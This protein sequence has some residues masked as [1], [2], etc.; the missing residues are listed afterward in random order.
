MIR[1]VR[2]GFVGASRGFTFIEL[3]VVSAVILVLAGA[4]M[5]LARVTMQRQREIE[6]RRTLRELRTAI[7]KYKD[8]VDA[9]L[10]GGIDVKTGSE[11]YPPDLQTLV[12]GVNRAGDASGAKL[13]FLRRIPVDPMTHGTDWGFRSYQDDAD[14]RSWGGQNVFDVHTTSEGKALD[15]TMYK[16]W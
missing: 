4:A 8:A 2:A 11:G 6:L 3:I 13:K 5:P 9:G 16:D 1:H 12:D 15:G 10:I 14:S 7:D